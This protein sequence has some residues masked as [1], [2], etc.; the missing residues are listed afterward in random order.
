MLK[1]KFGDIVTFV[2]FCVL[3]DKTRTIR[4]DALIFKEVFEH[5]KK[6]GIPITTFINKAVAEK[7]K[8][9]KKNDHRKAI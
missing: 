1:N 4:I 6:T 9:I 5:K 8:R 7:L 2:L 3:M